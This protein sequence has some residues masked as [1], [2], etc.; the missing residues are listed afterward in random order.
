MIHTKRSQSYLDDDHFD[1]GLKHR[2]KSYLKG[3]FDGKSIHDIGG[4]KIVKCIPIYN[5]NFQE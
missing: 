2:N 4:I 3:V 5:T 1:I